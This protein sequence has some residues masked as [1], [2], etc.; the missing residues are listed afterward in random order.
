MPKRLTDRE[1]TNPR[2]CRLYMLTDNGTFFKAK[3]SLP[4]S[5]RMPD[6]YV[7]QHLDLENP[8]SLIELAGIKQDYSQDFL[9]EKLHVDAGPID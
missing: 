2:L 5:S 9:I 8:G 1:I 6:D 7:I 4:I 3:I